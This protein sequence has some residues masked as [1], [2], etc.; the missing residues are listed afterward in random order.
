MFRPLPLV[1]LFAAL[2]A[3][4]CGGAT[5]AAPAPADAAAVTVSTAVAESVAL[6]RF[7]P[8]SGTLAA[9]EAAD[10]AAEIAGRVVATPVERGSRVGAH[11]DLVRVSAAEVEAQADEAAA[12]AGQIAARLGIADGT[13]F[14]AT[15]VPEVANA[16]ANRRLARTEFARAETLHKSQLI[17]QSEYEQKSAQLESAERQY[18]VAVNGAQ[19]Q[20]QSLLAARARMQLARKAV[21]D[22]VVRAPFAGVVGERVVAVGDYVTKGTKVASVMRIDPLRVELTVPAQYVSQ[23]ASGRTVTFAVDA[24]PGEAFT[25]QV[26]FVS[27]SVS[28]D[29][30]ALTIEAAVPNPDGKLKPGFFATARLEEA[31]AAP[32]IL[33]PAGAV[34]TVAG[35]ARVFVVN[36]DRVEERIVTTGQTEG[37]RIE[38]TDGV[39]A[40]ERVAI[41]EVDRLIDGLRVAAR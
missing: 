36:G 7:I 37:E 40:G 11:A 28:A 27:P 21:A 18:D 31:G 26:R 33:V 14:D 19:Q 10:V 32:G 16:D 13:A 29:S 4:G 17:S 2:A 39:K 3:A 23:V 8:V 9:E 24:Y 35:T 6:N 30:R 20:Y 25:G 1:V 41:T 15:R 38:I 5:T 34:R 22:T 12:N